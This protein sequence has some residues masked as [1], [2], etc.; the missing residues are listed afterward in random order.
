MRAVFL[1]QIVLSEAESLLKRMSRVMLKMRRGR[2]MRTLVSSW[3]LWSRV[4]R[5]GRWL[6]APRAVICVTAYVYY[7]TDDYQ[8]LLRIYELAAEETHLCHFE[9]MDGVVDG[10]SLFEEI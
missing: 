9:K 10:L 8:C 7:S 2:E 3:S 4:S 6:F 5:G 1:I